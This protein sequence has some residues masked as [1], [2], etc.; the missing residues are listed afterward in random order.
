[1][2][3]LVRRCTSSVTLR[4][5]R[6]T[7]FFKTRG[8]AK[9]FD[10]QEAGVYCGDAAAERYLGAVPGLNDW[11][12]WHESP[13]ALRNGH[14]HTIFAAKCRFTARVTY[15]RAFI[16]TPDGGTLAL[17]VVVG[18]DEEDDTYVRG[19]AAAA[20]A[21]GWRV[22]VLNMR[23]CAESPVTSPRFFS[24]RRGS[25]DDVRAAVDRIRETYGPSR[26]C[27][28]GW[29]NSGTIVTN[30]LAEQGD[31]AGLDA[32]CCLAAP[33]DMPTSS[34]NLEKP[35]HRNVY[36]RSIGGSLAEKVRG[37]RDLFLDEAGR[38]TAVPAWGGGTFV[39]DVDRAAAASTIRDVDEAITAPCFGFETVDAYYA[40]ASADQR[41]AAVAKPLL[42]VNAA[43][44]PIA[45]FTTKRG[46]FDFD[47]LAAN[48][49]VVAAV[50]AHGG[51]LG[52][53]D[54]A[55]PCGPPSWLQEN[56]LDFLDVA[57]LDAA[58][59]AALARRR[60]A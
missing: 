52:W 14:A 41:V 53:C 55:A 23:S 19:Q 3:L 40:D 2:L 5:P 20:H 34:A 49:N 39:A 11:S 37:A 10:K 59:R 44:D 48:P 32:A 31:A 7:T 9:D 22:A 4:P 29:S 26:L 12:R 21:R 36:D 51:H 24:A 33:L 38:P 60:A 15:A 1:M 6:A 25:T 27:A 28:I 50:T 46:V 47:A 30:A 42:V 13:P 18:A 8:T 16:D 54:A 45:R 56:A 57:A 17:D 35:F 43:D 58:D